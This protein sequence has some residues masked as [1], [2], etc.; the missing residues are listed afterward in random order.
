[1]LHLS[2]KEGLWRFP[3]DRAVTTIKSGE[4]HEVRAGFQRGRA[5]RGTGAGKWKSQVLE[6]AEEGTGA[7][8]SFTFKPEMGL[9]GVDTE[10]K[11]ERLV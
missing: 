4:W 3:L 1:M 7:L 2:K 8:P 11:G 10:G 5:E 9:E 6:N